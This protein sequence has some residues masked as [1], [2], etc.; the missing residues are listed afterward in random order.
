[1][2]D[3]ATLTAR[4][5]KDRDP[6]PIKAKMS[7]LAGPSGGPFNLELMVFDEIVRG[8]EEDGGAVESVKIGW[9]PADLALEDG[10][11]F[12]GDGAADAGGR[13]VTWG[14][15]R[16]EAQARVRFKLRLRCASAG[17]RRAITGQV[18]VRGRAQPLESTVTVDCTGP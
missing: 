3:A 1:M 16:L 12:P 15:R 11:I 5:R 14:A 8:G 18:R 2:R 9:E 6:M 17:G 4:G 13:G 10:S 7:Q